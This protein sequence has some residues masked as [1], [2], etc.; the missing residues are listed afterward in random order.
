MQYPLHDCVG[1]PVSEREDDLAGLPLLVEDQHG[2]EA[3]HGV[4]AVEEVVLKGGQ[5]PVVHRDSEAPG[6]QRDEDGH[7]ERDVAETRGQ[8]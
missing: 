4:E 3:G 6:Q 1:D 7:G 5:P 2:E 8:S